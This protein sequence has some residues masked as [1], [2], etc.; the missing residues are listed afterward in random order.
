M[1]SHNVLGIIVNT[2][3]LVGQVSFTIVFVLYH[4]ETAD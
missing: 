4:R 3:I 2:K 1:P